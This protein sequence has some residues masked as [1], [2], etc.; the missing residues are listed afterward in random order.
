M[1]NRRR[2]NAP[3]V[4]RRSFLMGLAA[5]AVAA[6]LGTLG[7]TKGRAVLDASGANVGPINAIVDSSP[8]ST[9]ISVLIEDA[10][11][12]TQALA[13][14]QN[15]SRG[16]VKEIRRDQE[17]SQFALTWTGSPDVSTF[18]RAERPDGTWSEWYQADPEM[19]ADSDNGLVGTELLYI[20]PTK[21]VQVSSNGLNI[22]GPGSG[23]EWK[24]IVGIDKLDLSTI[25]VE[26]LKS[27]GL[28]LGAIDPNTLA[29]GAL[30]AA[31]AGA[32]TMDSPSLTM[33]GM[34]Q[35]PSSADKAA[36]EIADE[37]AAAAG[38]GAADAGADAAATGETPAPSDVSWAEIKPVNDTL[39]LDVVNAIFIDGNSA[40]G[41]INPIA[42]GVNINGMPRVISRAQWGADE[43]KRGSA[44]YDS[45]LKAATVHHTAG[46]NN[47]TEAQAPGIVRGIYHYHA[48]TRGWGDIGYNALVDKFG[49][50]YEGR[51]GGLDKNVQGA[52]AGGFNKGTFGISMM[53]DYSSVQPS[54]AMIN[55][56]GEMI[57]WRLKIAGID[58]MGETTLTCAGF[59][60]AKYAAG[61]SVTLPAIF[62]HRNTGNT[63]CPGNSGYQQMGTIRTIAKQ[64]ASG[65][66]P[67]P[68]GAQR[69]PGSGT[70]GDQVADGSPNAGSPQVSNNTAVNDAARQFASDFGPEFQKFADS[71]GISP[72]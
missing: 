18:I 47:Y 72:R 70:V 45:K 61:E 5:T 30:G 63:P 53:G 28:D 22:F 31:T 38:A 66:V 34:P 6:P 58:P 9:A 23:V 21:A 8:L 64:G 71:L 44:S 52:H 67:K 32:P 33:P 40:E 69:S 17:F 25:D 12:A 41:T 62:A 46:S 29:A 1:P 19:A 36:G 13:D 60:G 43:S 14:A 59:S 26:A 2:I 55:S 49:N 10:A 24:D 15:P 27:L 11:I 68:G 57:G 37:A 7:L 54:Q 16:V 4:G 50:I 35:A 39:P 3:S 65:S 20:E 56:V 48:V 42:D 51:A